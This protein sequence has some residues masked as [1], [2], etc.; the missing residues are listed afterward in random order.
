MTE[1]FSKVSFPNRMIIPLTN[2][3]AIFEPYIHR[4]KAAHLSEDILLTSLG[5]DGLRQKLSGFARIKMIDET[6]D[7]RLSET[8]DALIEVEPFTDGVVG[9]IVDALLGC[10][11]AKHVG[12]KGGVSTFLVGHKLDER[13]LFG[14]D[15]GLEKLGF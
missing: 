15:T 4:S 10:C 13:H 14:S 7:T 12:Q 3:P 6:P 8:S 9:I 11:L 2:S 5:S 1:A